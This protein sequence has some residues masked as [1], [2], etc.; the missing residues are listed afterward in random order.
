MLAVIKYHNHA[1]LPEYETGN[2]I[3]VCSWFVRNGD[4]VLLV[5]TSRTGSE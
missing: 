4:I 1:Y 2:E 3:G 5:S